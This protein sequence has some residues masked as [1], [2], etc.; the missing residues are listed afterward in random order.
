MA[1]KKPSLMAKIGK[2]GTAAVKKR[3]GDPVSADSGSSLPAGIENAIA[4][5]TDCYF[6]QYKP[7]TKYEG[8][9][10]FRAVGT[11]ISPKV[12]EGVPIEGCQ[13]SIIEPCCDTPDAGGKRKTLEDRIAF[14]LNEMRKLGLDTSEATAEQLENMA[15][16]LKTS[17]PYFRLRTW[18]GDKQTTGPYAGK[19]PRVNEVWGGEVDMEALAEAVATTEG[20]DD[21]LEDTTAT[22]EGDGPEIDLDQLAID[23][24]DDHDS[25]VKL[26]E[27]AAAVG[28][29]ADTIDSWEGVVAAINEAEGNA[30]PAE[31]DEPEVDP[32]DEPEPEAEAETD[33][34]E[35][36]TPS[37]GDLA[38]YKPPKM[39]N[40][41]ICK[42][43]T[44]NVKKETCG[45]K[46]A[47]KGTIYKNVPWD[48][49]EV[50]EDEE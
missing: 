12:F 8:E 49:I 13:T 23:A 2:K 30:E 15:E 45:L 31:D 25:A 35:V 9:F 5:L 14:I 37:K 48:K 22:A 50:V 10:F 24:D 38:M 36:A 21:D 43:M 28:V 40:A 17:K 46:E 19:E 20:D 16:V 47:K 1:K 29:D 4:Q 34:E 33:E 11:I 44:S 32:D 3:K 18:K 39:K 41:R 27:I 6:G 42:V 7:G 26:T